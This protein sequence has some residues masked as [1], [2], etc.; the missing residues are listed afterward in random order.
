MESVLSGV[1]E[2]RNFIDRFV[3]LLQNFNNLN[4]KQN[5]FSWPPRI[6][7]DLG[8]DDFPYVVVLLHGLLI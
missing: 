3:V 6:G 1:C 2:E 8:P 4:E 7:V 5:Y